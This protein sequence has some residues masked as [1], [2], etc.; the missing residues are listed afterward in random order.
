MKGPNTWGRVC[1][2]PQKRDLQFGLRFCLS[3]GKETTLSLIFCNEMGH[4]RLK[5]CADWK[6]ISASAEQACTEVPL[7]MGSDCGQLF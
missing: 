5:G 4:N 6:E 1:V 3:Q 2:T 7:K